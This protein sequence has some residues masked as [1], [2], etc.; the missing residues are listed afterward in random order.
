MTFEDV[1]PRHDLATWK[2]PEYA[3]VAASAA[4]AAKPFK[5]Q[6]QWN[7]C[8]VDISLWRPPG[9]ATILPIHLRE[10]SIADQF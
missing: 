2:T 1:I 3:F 10:T 6:L 7:D 5:Q 4:N 8:S 9:C